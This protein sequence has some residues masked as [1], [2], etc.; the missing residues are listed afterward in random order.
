MDVGST[1]CSGNYLRVATLSPAVFFHKAKVNMKKR[2]LGAVV[3]NRRLVRFTEA[4]M[5]R[6]RSNY[7]TLFKTSHNAFRF[8]GHFVFENIFFH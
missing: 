6:N 7:G 8:M 4:G 2:L 3:E 1:G 5:G